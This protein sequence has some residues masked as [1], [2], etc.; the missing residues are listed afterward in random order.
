[1]IKFESGAL[2]TTFLLDDHGTHDSDYN[3][4]QSF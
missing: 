2:N 1:M 3:L 4:L